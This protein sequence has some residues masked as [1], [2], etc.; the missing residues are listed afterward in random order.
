MGKAW[1]SQHF[2][3]RRMKIKPYNTH[4]QPNNGNWNQR[5][6]G[7]VKMERGWGGEKVWKGEKGM[8]GGKKVW[9]VMGFA[10]GG[11]TRTLGGLRS[12]TKA[13]TK[14]GCA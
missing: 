1:Q 14:H 6:G 13:P 7:S 2:I 12:V 11:G 5:K 8:E 4:T 10:K 3:D 9:K